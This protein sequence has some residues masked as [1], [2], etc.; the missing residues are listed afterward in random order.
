MGAGIIRLIRVEYLLSAARERGGAW[1]LPR[2]QELREVPGALATAEEAAAVLE[3]AD[4][5]VF[6]MS[7]GISGTVGSRRNGSLGVGGG[8]SSSVSQRTEIAGRSDEDRTEISFIGNELRHMPSAAP[9]P[10]SMQPCPVTFAAP[11][12][13]RCMP[14]NTLSAFV[15]LPLRQVG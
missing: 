15:W 12:C 2:L 14:S 11:C 10:R 6:S 5:S 7:Y 8:S 1:R 4:R 13:P 3:R 9:L